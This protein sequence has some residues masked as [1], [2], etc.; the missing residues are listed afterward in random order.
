MTEPKIGASLALAAAALFV[1]TGMAAA[2]APGGDPCQIRDGE[3]FIALPDN[4][5]GP[6]P[7]VIWLHGFGGS[8]GSAMRGRN[9]V[10]PLLDNGYAVIAPQGTPMGG[11]R[12]GYRWNFRGDPGLAERD[13]TAFL[14]SVRTDAAARFGI[15][16]SRVT[17]GGFSNGAFLVSYIACETPGAFDSYAPVSGTFWRPH[18]DTCEGPVR[19]F[20][21]HGWHDTVVPLEGRPLGGGR[22]LQGDVFAGLEIWREANQCARPDA[23]ETGLDGAFLRRSWNACA[24]GASLEFALFDGG[25]TV[26]DGWAEMLVSWL[27][28]GGGS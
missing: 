25:H 15:D 27:E 20:Q 10:P 12:R 7:A 21:T 19:L 5:E 24:P 3:Y 2:C 9:V 16:A 6:V 17:L 18:P 14:Q 1:G 4:A 11:D 13:E 22:F 26:P 28:E 8:A 23:D